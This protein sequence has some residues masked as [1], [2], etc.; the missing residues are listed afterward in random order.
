MCQDKPWGFGFWN[1]KTLDQ[2]CAQQNSNLVFVY[3]KQ[4][5]GVGFLC[6]NAKIMGLIPS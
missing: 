4:Y 5:C 2:S 3:L 1:E 6:L